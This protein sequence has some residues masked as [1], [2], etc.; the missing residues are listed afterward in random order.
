MSMYTD[1]HSIYHREWRIRVP[2]VKNRIRVGTWVR[3]NNRRHQTI[4]IV[5]TCLARVIF[6]SP[7]VRTRKRL[8]SD[9]YCRVYIPAR[10][11]TLI[12]GINHLSVTMPPAGREVK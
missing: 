3:V 8:G 2:Q 4:G 11:A 12:V 1:G 10:K 9:N 7:K 6:D 5:K